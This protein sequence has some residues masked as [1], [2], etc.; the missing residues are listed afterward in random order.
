MI[1][2]IAVA[3]IGAIPPT[4]FAIAAWRRASK[5][6]KPLE[7]VNE[8]VNHRVGGQK[9]L[10]EVIDEVAQSMVFISEAVTRVEEDL[11][12]HRAWHRKQDEELDLS[13]ADNTDSEIE[14]KEYDDE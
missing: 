12:T 10:I 1:T 13:P 7:Q 5:L 4:I 6:S 8:A 2:E 9:K 11:Q 3:L 14:S